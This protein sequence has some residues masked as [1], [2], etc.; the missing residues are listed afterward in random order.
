MIVLSLLM[1]S[2]L[3]LLPLPGV[4][5]AFR[6]E[7]VAMTLIY[8][9]M[10]LPQRAGIGLAWITGLFVD[11]MMGEILG[12]SA[13]SYVLIVYLVLRLHLQLRQHPLWQQAFI[14]LLLVLPVQIIDVVMSPRIMN[15]QIWLPTISSAIIW[16]FIYAVL[17]K[18]RHIFNVR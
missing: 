3:M 17:R 1:A 6:P 11:V 8:W 16:P 18:F 14:I 15:W 4:V 2:A 5:S 10:A 12:V 13:L 9:A 7:W